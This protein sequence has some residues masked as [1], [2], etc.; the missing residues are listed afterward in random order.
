MLYVIFAANEKNQT[1]PYF[2]GRYKFLLSSIK[3]DTRLQRAYYLFFVLRR[4]SLI[5]IG[6]SLSH[7]SWFQ[8]QALMLSNLIMVIYLASCDSYL[9]NFDRRMAI[10]TEFFT[11]AICFHL[12]VYTDFVANKET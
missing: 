5:Q 11:A 12:I 1:N 6:M 10:F 2:N 7:H 8:V 3:T 4:F 9:T